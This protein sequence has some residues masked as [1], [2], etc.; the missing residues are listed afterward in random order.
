MKEPVTFVI[1]PTYKESRQVEKILRCMARYR[2][3]SVMILIANGNPGD[4]T[5]RHIESLRS[6]RILELKGH[7]ALY[8]SG[9]VNL[10]LRYVMACEAERE[11]VIIMNADI[12]FDDDII[13]LM[14]SKARTIP[15]CQTRC[16]DSGWPRSDLERREGG[17]L[18][19]DAQ[20][21]PAR[22]VAAWAGPSGLL[23]CGGLSPNALHINPVRGGR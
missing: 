20:P 22:R 23:G 8:W 6:D 12:V 2:T 7:S 18:G 5:T 4:E 11:F 15:C 9:L 14:T 19:V 21:T 10:G 16:L 17:L 3:E 1:I 13:S